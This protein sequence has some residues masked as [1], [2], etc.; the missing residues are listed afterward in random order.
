MRRH[1]WGN[2]APARRRSPDIDGWAPRARSLLPSITGESA[3][4]RVLVRIDRRDDSRLSPPKEARHHVLASV[5]LPNLYQTVSHF[6]SL[7][8]GTGSH[9]GIAQHIRK[10]RPGARQTHATRSSGAAAVINACLPF[11]G[12][13][14]R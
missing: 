10:F 5:A 9:I 4:R 13:E 8:A 2:A 3:T 1:P 12:D 11:R 14:N 6:H 7:P